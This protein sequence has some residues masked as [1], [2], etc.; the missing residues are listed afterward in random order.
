MSSRSCSE[1]QQSTNSSPSTRFSYKCALLQS[2]LKS[3]VKTQ[4]QRLLFT[5]PTQ[6]QVNFELVLTPRPSQSQKTT[7]IL[8]SWVNNLPDYI[9]PHPSY[10]APSALSSAHTASSTKFIT[11]KGLESTRWGKKYLLSYYFLYRSVESLVLTTT[12]YVVGV[13]YS[14]ARRD[15]CLYIFYRRSAK[16]TKASFTEQ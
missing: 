16:C 10:F 5:T 11:F 8:N 7:F 4:A 1:S 14:C 6:T 9:F 15:I 2:S 12:L 13:K 3:I